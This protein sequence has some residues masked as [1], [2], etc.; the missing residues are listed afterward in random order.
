[1]LSREMKQFLLKTVDLD[2]DPF[3]ITSA[4]IESGDCSA[5]IKA[6][7][8]CVL[9]GLEEAVYLFES[10]K[11]KTNSN[12]KDGDFVKKNSTVLE[13]TGNNKTILG[14]E[15]IALNIL[16]KMSGVATLCRETKKIS[17]DL[18][19]LAVTRKTTPG[20]ND[21]EKKAAKLAGVKPH[22]KNLGDGVLIKDN[23]LFFFENDIVKALKKAKSK[24]FSEAIEIEVETIEHA[25]D[26]ARAGASIIML[27]NF[28]VEN[29]KNTIEVLREKFPNV[30]IELS[31]GITNENLKEYA[32]LKPDWISLGYLTK[33]AVIKDFSL[34][35]VD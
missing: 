35:V 14:I 11:C 29:A 2:N 34:E 8:D 9:A 13:L 27:D 15:R 7:E 30:K 28:S 17:G 10:S 23:H 18:T 31:G 12:T 4:I 32:E 1:M 22:R 26:A 20:F 6:K 21:F 25:I 19:E 3:D 33:N 16:G 24:K 5:V